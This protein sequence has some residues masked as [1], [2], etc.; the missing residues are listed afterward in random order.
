MTI[1]KTSLKEQN[2]GDPIPRTIRTCVNYLEQDHCLDIEG[3]FR[4]SA[5]VNVVKTV[6][7]AFN[8][9]EKINF[10]SLNLD[11]EMSLEATVHVAAV[12][13]KSFLR[14]LPEPLLTFQLYDDVI[15]FQQISGGPTPEQRQEKL[16]SAKNLVLNRLPEINYHV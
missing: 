8:M 4:R 1:K 6:Q 10:N 5:K 12:I 7:Q 16:Q 11:E 15:N 9:G 13:V 3:V 14:E 2:G